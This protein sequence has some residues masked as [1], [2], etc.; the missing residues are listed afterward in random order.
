[1][2]ISIRISMLRILIQKVMFQITP[3]YY[4]LEYFTYIYISNSFSTSVSSIF[5]GSNI[6]LPPSVVNMAFP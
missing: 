3:A 2:S 1:M 6:M 5:S 4:A